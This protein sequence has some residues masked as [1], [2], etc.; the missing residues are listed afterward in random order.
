MD[1]LRAE[2][3]RRNHMI[4]GLSPMDGIT[5]T[6]FREIVD[7][8]GHPDLLFTEFVPVEAISHGVTRVLISLRNHRTSTRTLA[9]FFGRDL[10]AYY[11]SSFV[12]AELGFDGIDINMGCP[13]KNIAKKGGGAGLI[14]EPDLAVSIIKTVKEA[15]AD[16]QGGKSMREARLSDETVSWIEN[17]RLKIPK[18]ILLPVSVKT[19]TGLDAPITENW[20]SRLIEAG[21]DMISLH[22]RT[23]IQLYRGKADWEEIQKASQLVRQAGITFLGNGDVKTV[24]QAKEYASRYDCDGILIGRAALGNPWLFADKR[25]TLAEIREAMLRHCRAFL[26]YRPELKLYPMRKHLA[27]YMTGFEG[28]REIRDRMMRVVTID[29][30]EKLLQSLPI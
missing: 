24:S 22:G 2:T 3:K 21:P 13:D 28:S 4:I 18:R 17:N 10:K 14:A 25:P 7:M 8:Y 5:D 20:I 27:W 29:D 12:A 26:H 19:R 1:I 11:K 16:W 15:V 9:Q 23:L 6:A 30:V